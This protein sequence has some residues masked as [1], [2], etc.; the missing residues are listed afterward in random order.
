MRIFLFLI[1]LA[2][3]FS[4]WALGASSDDSRRVE[5]NKRE[6]LDEAPSRI[7]NDNKTFSFESGGW[8]NY[9]FSRY[10]NTDN[11]KAVPDDI[12][13]VHWGDLRVWGKLVYQTP[14]MKQEDRKDSF[15]L[16]LKDT[17]RQRSGEDPQERY[18]NAGPLVDY[19][20]GSF[21]TGPWK[22]EAGRRYFNLGR[23]I[24]FSGVFDGVQI[25]YQRPGWNVGWLAAATKPHEQNIDTSVPGYDK[26]SRRYFIGTGVGYAGITGHQLYGF[27]L[28]EQDHSREKPED[29]LQDYGY[30]AH[31]AGIGAKGEWG[32]RWPYWVE[33]V[34]QRGRSKE[35]F[36]NADADIRAWA[37][38]AEQKYLTRWR[39]GLTFSAEYAQG[40]GDSDRVDVTST[41]IGSQAGRDRNFMYFGY[42]PTG[43]A[44]SPLLSN[45]KMARIGVSGYPFFALPRLEQMRW[46][47]DYYQYW[48][49]RASG[50]ISDIDATESARGIGQE[51][52][53]RMDWRWNQR[54]ILS[55]EWGYFVPG[56]AYPDTTQAHEKVV[57]VSLSYIF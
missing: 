36:S 9:R 42:A 33:A 21:D 45:L 22:I 5:E 39:S 50:G 13:D 14:Q 23:G 18:D 56:K 15:Y 2:W 17:Y 41:V 49:E 20:Y 43:V 37:F 40:S 31:Y 11:N 28:T 38:D 29:P 30:D 10:E 55:A 1:V 54:V 26:D 27:Q 51:L 8:V 6:I 3:P 24:V 4:A 53:L 12:D 52:D 32:K 44:L 34:G 47:M 7:I 25:N 16:R 57:S 48:K 19:A 35:Y 46:H